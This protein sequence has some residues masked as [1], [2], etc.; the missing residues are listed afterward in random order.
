VNAEPVEPRTTA[1]LP[2]APWVITGML[3]G[4]VGVLWLG[5]AAGRLAGTVVGAPAGSG[6]SAEFVRAL[7]AGRW[8]QA[9]PGVP[10]LLA[11]AVYAALLLAAA[12]PLLL[13]WRL[14]RRRRSRAGDPLPSLAAARDLAT[15]SPAGVTARAGHLRPGLA[16]RR[17]P[18]EQAGLPLGRLVQPG[19]RS[20]PLLRA[21][22]EDVNVALM[23]PRTG[24]TTGLAVPMLLEAP[25]PTVATSVKPDLW[26]TTRAWRAARGTVWNF[27]PQTITGQPQTWWW[28]PLTHI[29]G[30]EEAGRFADHFVQEISRGKPADFWTNGAR[31]VISALVLAAAVGGRTLA[32]VQAWLS[33]TTDG[34]PAHILHQHGFS[35]KAHALRGRQAGAPETREGTYETARTAAVCLEDPTIMAWVTPPAEPLPCFDLDTFIGSTDTLYLHSTDNEGAPSP[36]VAG[37]VDQIMHTAVRHARHHGGR[38][39]PPL[40][41]LLDEAANICRIGDLPK[42]YSYMGSHGVCITTILQSYPQGTQVWGERGMGAL[43]SAATIKL[44]GAG[45]DDARFAEDISRLVGEHDIPTASRSR[46]ARG[47]TNYHINT[48]RRR[49]LDPGQIRALPRGTALLLASGA[50]PALIKLQPWYQGPHAGRLHRDL[51]T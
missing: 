5:W 24:K 44:V 30:V 48:H 18:P 29:T 31:G 37:F 27:D 20:G 7:L 14:W 9:W 50:K 21:S 46:D 32:D 6:F 26:Q 28:N 33:N 13:G 1:G 22:W 2:L 40:V 47:S 51:P 45:T 23:G 17:I 3:Y 35:Q 10:P 12:V 43:W 39:D 15:L 42:L 41:A 11:A 8:A 34:E 49:I 16:G 4:G 19:R 38:I 36:L 25:G